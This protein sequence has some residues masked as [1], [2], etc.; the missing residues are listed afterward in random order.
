MLRTL[1]SLTTL[2]ALAAFLLLATGCPEQAF[3]EPDYCASL[4]E[5]QVS[6]LLLG[7]PYEGFAPLG[8]E[9]Y[10]EVQ[11]GPQGGAMF[12]FK[13]RAIG[14]GLPTCMTVDVNL[15]ADDGADL[16]SAQVS[17]RFLEDEGASSR[18]SQTLRI[19]LP[20]GQSFEGRAATLTATIGPAEGRADVIL[21]E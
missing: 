10:S 7:D 17:V 19:N 21:H 2:I 12:F 20:Y 4:E 13:V 5:A 18:T 8:P 11:Y 14:A 16:G 1:H 3:E 9:S 6:G 15:Q